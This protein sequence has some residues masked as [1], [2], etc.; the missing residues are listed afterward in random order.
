MERKKALQNSLAFVVVILVMGC[1]PGD[2]GPLIDMPIA[3][4]GKTRSAAFRL[5]ADYTYD[6]AIGLDPMKVDEATCA[7][8][9]SALNPGIPYPP[10]HELTPP[11]GAMSWIVTQ[12]SKVIAQGRMDASPIDVVRG[13]PNSWAKDKT[14]GWYVSRGWFG[15]PGKDYVI[16][17]DVQ[18]SPEDLAQY[19]PRLAIL[20]PFK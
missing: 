15:H 9:L 8:R 16:Q 19:H 10:C 17:I 13:R 1:E 6:I 14:M 20:K 4:V 7:P 5:Y 11:L 18:P 2:F 3:P 12:G